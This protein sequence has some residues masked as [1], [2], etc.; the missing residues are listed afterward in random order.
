VKPTAEFFARKREWSRLK[1]EILGT[2]LAPYFAKIAKTRRSILIVDAF[3]GKG[4][5]D[6]GEPGSPVIILDAILR[7]R[8]SNPGA[9]IEALFIERKYYEDLAANIAGYADGRVL[10]GTYE[11]HVKALA[12]AVGRDTSVLLFVDPY[13]VKSL[14]FGYFRA[15]AER[16]LGSLELIL[17][18]NTFGFLREGCRLL[19]MEGF[20]CGLDSTDYD[21]DPDSRN[22]IERMNAVAGGDHWQGFLQ[23]YHARGRDIRP[24]ERAF[25]QEYLCRLR[26][27][28][29]HVVS[30]PV[31]EKRSH[32]PKYRLFF[33]TQHPD[34][35]ILMA[36]KMSRVWREFVNRD[37][38]GQGTLFEEIDFP[39]MVEL[40]GYSL[41]NDIL[42]LAAKPVELKNLLVQLFER[43]GITYSLKD[44]RNR[45]SE[46]SVGEGAP[47]R[48]DRYPPRTPTGRLSRSMDFDE[49]KI[50]V[51]RG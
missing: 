38:A 4:R 24:A 26:G 2:Y 28:F 44:L 13:G 19:G 35:L 42:Q 18:F 29:R 6:D 36:D 46:L 1:D 40:E 33:G 30:I 34:G 3:A 9:Q 11:A 15:L 48:I 41:D 22:S 49:Y 39:D 25:T 45:I 8:S 12:E 31:Q 14:D 5:F 23:E 20:D 50:I 10:P 21:D 17:N 47:L 7:T 37:R 43:Y 51:R 16:R 27:L 32:L